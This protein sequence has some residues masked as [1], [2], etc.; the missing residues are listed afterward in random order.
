MLSDPAEDPATIDEFREAGVETKE[1][2][3]DLFE[4]RFF[5]GCEADDPMNAIDL[6]AGGRADF[7]AGTTVG[8]YAA[9][10]VERS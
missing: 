9:G 7:F 6:L 3:R 8:D 1:E 2:I 5:F 10:L 4:Q